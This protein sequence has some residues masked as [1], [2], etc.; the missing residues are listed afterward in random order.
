MQRYLRLVGL[1]SALA[2]WGP[3]GADSPL[4]PDRAAFRSIYQELLET[5]T[6]LS[7]GSCTEAAARM[8]A[9]LRAAGFAESDIHY[10]AVPEHPKEGGVV[11]VL[12]GR[13]P[14]AKPMLLLAHIDVVEARREDWTRDP[15]KLVEEGGY[16]YARGA[17]DDKFQAAVWVDTL[18]RLHA[19]K[20][21]P[22]R[23]IKMALTC[24]EETSGA[25]NGAAY[26][27][28]HE[29]AL[30][31]AE[32]ALNEGAFGVLDES[33]KRVV[34][35]VQAGEKASQNYTLEVINPG[36][37]SSRPRKDNAI[38]DLA[39]ALTKVSEYQFPLQFNATTTT[40]FRRMAPIVGGEMGAAMKAIADN[41]ADARAAEVL[42]RDPGY[43][44]LLHT[45]C[46]ATM[47]GGGHATNALPQRAR[48]NINCRVFPGTA[49]EAVRARLQ[50]I[51]GNP[52]VSVT[53]EATRGPAVAPPPL[54]PA[55]MAP[56]ETLA[57]RHFPG[58]PVVPVQQS[59]GTDGIYLIAAGIPTYGISGAF[60][61]P[62]LGHI[63]GLNERLAVQSAYD[64]RDFLFDL[65][66]A[67]AEKQHF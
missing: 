17:M 53:M 15:F 8:G 46:V 20:P 25:F 48:A 7:N 54:T 64:A 22:A 60:V 50:E 11:A 33:G 14:A 38:Y 26:L 40:Y 57:A 66:S 9:R 45:T 1:F 18:I 19:A 55:I 56:I 29:R 2:V 49:L 34:V 42:E 61:E 30:I 6:A 41:P 21:R 24:G 43:N 4:R 52:G 32:F 28:S 65:V 31:D 47:L 35:E 51:V 12:A 63:H 10:F 59:G 37:H 36:G 44:G 5:N 23:T 13:D 62:D 58:V 39:A 16:F 67:L 3:A 27:A